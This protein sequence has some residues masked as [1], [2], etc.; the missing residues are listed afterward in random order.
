M[1]SQHVLPT[2]AAYSA[3]IDSR[4]HTALA[5]SM[6]QGQK[7]LTLSW[8]SF[9]GH[10]SNVVAMSFAK[11]GGRQCDYGLMSLPSPPDFRWCNAKNRRRSSDVALTF[12]FRMWQRAYH[13]PLL[14]LRRPIR[15]LW[16]DVTMPPIDCRMCKTVNYW[17]SI[18]AHFN[19]IETAFVHPIIVSNDSYTHYWHLKLRLYLLPFPFRIFITSQ[20][21]ISGYPRYLIETWQG[22]ITFLRFRPA[23]DGM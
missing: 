10:R 3:I 13:L 17:H 22:T 6:M 14:L 23:I 5:C 15:L 2:K 7:S 8:R 18:D 4:C 11:T 1:L 20:F 9:L 16:K 21:L 12:I 19:H